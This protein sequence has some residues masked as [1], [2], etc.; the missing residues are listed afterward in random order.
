MKAG[1]VSRLFIC[2]MFVRSYLWVLGL[3]TW[4]P[5][6]PPKPLSGWQKED[7]NAK[8][9]MKNPWLPWKFSI[10]FPGFSPHP[11][12]SLCSRLLCPLGSLP[13]QPMGGPGM[14][15]QRLKVVL[16]PS[17]VDVTWCPSL[18]PSMDQCLIGSLPTSPSLVCP[19]PSL[20]SCV[21][22]FAKPLQWGFFLWSLVRGH[23]TDHVVGLGH[24]T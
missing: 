5:S 12:P 3:I 8:P 11:L 6:H 13:V 20:Y 23:G 9:R 15:R 2:S 10:W 4:C 1:A 21:F 14:R 17:L 19:S 24:M 18:C 16:P 22:S 7:E